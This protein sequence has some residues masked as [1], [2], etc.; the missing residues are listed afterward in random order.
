MK[1]VTLLKSHIVY[2]KTDIHVYKVKSNI[3]LFLK[4]QVHHQN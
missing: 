4:R 3:I 2:T 1:N